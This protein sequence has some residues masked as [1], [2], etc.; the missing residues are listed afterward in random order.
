MLRLKMQLA[1]STRFRLSAVIQ[2]LAMLYLHSV[3]TGKFSGSVISSK[4]RLQ[5]YY[6]I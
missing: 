5:L 4:R 3:A 1:I 6:E 2:L